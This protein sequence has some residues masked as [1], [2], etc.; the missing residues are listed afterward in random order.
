VAY[1]STAGRQ[2]IAGRAALR[3]AQRTRWLRLC[4]RTSAGVLATTTASNVCVWVERDVAR[5]SG[6]DAEAEGQRDRRRCDVAKFRI[7]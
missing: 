3:N 6:D 1:E 2:R 5:R 7:S 4:S